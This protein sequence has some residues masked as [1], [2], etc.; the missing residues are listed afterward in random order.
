MDPIDASVLEED[1][2]W[3][4]TLQDLLEAYRNGVDGAAWDT[5]LV[6]R[7]WGFSLASIR[8]PVFLWHGEQDRY[9]P[10]SMARYLAQTIPN[11]RATFVPNM[12]HLSLF[13]RFA[14]TYLEAFL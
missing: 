11:C 6:P 13:V 8:V 14:D 10:P 9:A 2:L 12:G 4:W 5:R 3:S 1:G 7:P